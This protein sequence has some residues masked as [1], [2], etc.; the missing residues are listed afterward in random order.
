[1]RRVV[2]TLEVEQYDE[3]RSE[4][5]EATGMR[6]LVLTGRE[7]QQISMNHDCFETLDH[8]WY[9]IGRPLCAG[10]SN[11]T[12][13]YIDTN[14]SALCR[15]IQ[16]L[17][18][19]RGRDSPDGEPIRLTFTL[20]LCYG[21]RSTDYDG[22]DVDGPGVLEPAIRTVPA[23]KSSV[24]SLKRKRAMDDNGDDDQRAN[25][26]C[27]ICQDELGKEGTSVA[28]PCDHEFHDK[29]IV[30]WLEQAHSCPICRFKLPTD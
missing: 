7:S 14:G 15:S 4:G 30:R 25:K 29:C 5:Q 26:I 3:Q 27:V 13:A 12:A 17:V 1:M 19:V 9:H 22:I 18:H 16:Q 23:S 2:L 20:R 10:R 28:M 8:I 6:M 24:Q 11:A 21:F